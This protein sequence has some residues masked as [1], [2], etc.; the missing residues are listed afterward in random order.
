MSPQTVRERRGRIRPLRAGFGGE[1]ANLQNEPTEVVR[2]S[3]VAKSIS[4]DKL[5]RGS[6]SGSIL[7]YVSHGEI[8]AVRVMKNQ[9]ADARLR[10]H[11]E[12]L[13]ELHADLFR[14]QELPDA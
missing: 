14:L 12:A 13:S 7:T 1:K 11:H 2:R 8:R 5:S 6:A 9:R 3:K 10:V 4:V